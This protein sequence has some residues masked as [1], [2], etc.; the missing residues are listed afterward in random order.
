MKCN[1]VLHSSVGYTA[2]LYSL[3]ESPR[4]VHKYKQGISL[5]KSK[6]NQYLRD[7]ILFLR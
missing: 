7:F 3:G 4:C 2:L 5:N 1:F 6:H